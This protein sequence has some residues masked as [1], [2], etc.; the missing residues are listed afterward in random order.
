MKITLLENG[1]DSLKKGYQSLKSYEEMYFIDKCGSERYLTLK[2]AVLAIHHGI[3][4]LF[5]EVLTKT[6]ELLVFSEIDKNLKN[7]FVIKRQ[8]NLSSIFEAD[9]SLHTVTFSEALDR[10][11]KICGH[12]ITKNFNE[13]LTKLQY[14]RNQITHSEVLI[15]E[16]QLNSVFEGLVD[17]IDTFFIKAIGKSYKTITGYSQLQSNYYEYIKTLDKTKDNI[18]IEAISKFLSAFKN[19]SISMGENEVKIIRDINTAFKFI[20]TLYDSNLSFGTDLYNGYCSGNVN[21]I[22]RI[23]NKRLALYTKD[24][25]A[26][27][28]FKFS[29]LLIFMPKIDS[30][31]S[32]I[33]FFESAED[34]IEKS[35]EK[36][37]EFDSHKRKSISGLYFVSESR[38]EWDSEKINEFYYKA[39]AD[40]YFL[41][42]EY[43]RVEHFLSAG[44]FCF[45]NVQMLNYG[46]MNSLLQDFGKSPLKII[47]VKIRRALK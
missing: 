38:T 5:K 8:R 39:D 25:R 31:L 32:P 4:I 30:E 27:Y 46:R 18:K 20:E 2:D 29:S 26:E 1:I 3:E 22:K 40:E 43:H 47:E 9:Q 17:E 13:K 7:A 21:K 37:I 12:E 14:Y 45:I 24:N 42:P 33:M 6:N 15:D 16:N 19:C 34:H 11:Q 28:I 23:D 44:V 10:V 41:I 35:L 36:N